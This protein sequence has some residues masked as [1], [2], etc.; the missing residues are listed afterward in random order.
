MQ[1]DTHPV[2]GMNA[3]GNEL[4]GQLIGASI[5]VTVT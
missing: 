4:P 2:T 5:K 1:K 3:Q